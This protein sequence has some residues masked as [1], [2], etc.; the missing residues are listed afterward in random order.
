[1]EPAVA[2]LRAALETT[3]I[4]RPAFPVVANSCCA[5]LQDAEAIRAEL[6]RQVI[7][8]VRWRESLHAMSGLDPDVW[9]DSGP[10]TVMAGLLTRTLAGA[11]CEALSAYI[12]AADGVAAPTASASPR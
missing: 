12:D 5:L 6:V 11:R 3:P 10:G 2:T 9:I 1:M 7:A 4:C 8:P